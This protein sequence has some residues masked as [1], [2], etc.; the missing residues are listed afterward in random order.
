MQEAVI[1]IGF[2]DPM[3]LPYS[4]ALTLNGAAAYWA[5]LHMRMDVKTS[6]GMQV[7]GRNEATDTSGEIQLDW[8]VVG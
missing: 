3:P 2:A 8:L 1:S 6:Y 5:S 4:A 7:V